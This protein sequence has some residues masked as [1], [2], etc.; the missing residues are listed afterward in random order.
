MNA[1]QLPLWGAMPQASNP[2]QTPD[3]GVCPRGENESTLNLDPCKGCPLRE[4]CGPD[5][6]GMKLYETD[7]NEPED[8]SFEDWLSDP[9]Y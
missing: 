7:I 8:Y 2:A 3:L 6:C 1:I 9:L 4:V 5:D